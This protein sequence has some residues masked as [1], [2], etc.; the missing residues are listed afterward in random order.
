MAWVQMKLDAADVWMVRGIFMII[1][2]YNQSVI[3]IS[4]GNF[5]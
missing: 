1:S 5:V 2:F 4:N 3:R